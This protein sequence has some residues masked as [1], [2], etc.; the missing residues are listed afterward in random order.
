MA[1]SQRRRSP[2]LQTKLAMRPKT[3]EFEAGGIGLPI[4]QHEI[5]PNMAVPM[6]LPFSRQLVVDMAT[7]Q[8]L[9]RRQQIDHFHQKGI[10]LFG[11][12]I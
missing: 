11:W 9:I 1:K 2:S 12:N 10:Q 7:Q 6:I 8:R 5:R 4:D 3:H